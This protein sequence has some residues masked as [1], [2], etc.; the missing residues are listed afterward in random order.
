[1]VQYSTGQFEPPFCGIDAQMKPTMAEM[2]RGL[3][4]RY[5]DQK[6]LYLTLQAQNAAAN[7]LGK[8]LQLKW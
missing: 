1:M 8:N 3:G 5:R 4:N 6:R 7:A 2:L